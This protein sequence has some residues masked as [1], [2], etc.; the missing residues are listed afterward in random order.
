MNIISFLF[1][2]KLSTGL[3]IAVTVLVLGM[4]GKIYLLNA[5]LKVEKSNVKA[6]KA[7][8]V[9]AIKAQELV[10]AMLEAN[11]VEYESNL[12]T[13]GE[14]IARLQKEHDEKTKII[15]DRWRDKNA[16]CEDAMYWLNHYN[17]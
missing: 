6:E 4:A 5:D 17:F 8:K 13:A 1:G 15:E 2:S 3:T 12:E 16:T 10:S 7:E 11:R 14:Q 9:Q